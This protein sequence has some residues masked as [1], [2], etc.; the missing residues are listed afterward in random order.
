MIKKKFILTTFF[1][2]VD[3]FRKKRKQDNSGLSVTAEATGILSNL[4]GTFPNYPRPEVDQS[5]VQ[6][7]FRLL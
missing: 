6:W 2:I 4:R 7:A 5:K 1:G 3:K